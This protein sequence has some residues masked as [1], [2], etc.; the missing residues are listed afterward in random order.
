MRAAKEIPVKTTQRVCMERTT[1]ANPP[2]SKEEDR[3]RDLVRDQAGNERPG[4]PHAPVWAVYEKCQDS[5]ETRA[6]PPKPERPRRES[7]GER[8]DGK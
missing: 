8:Q 2:E 1:L 4:Q 5:A 7:D 3:G 6:A